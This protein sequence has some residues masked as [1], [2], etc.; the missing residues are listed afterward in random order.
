MINFLKKIFSQN[1]GYKFSLLY[2]WLFNRNSYIAH[3]DYVS[4]DYKQKCVHIMEAMNYVKVAQ[5][6]KVF[7]EFGCHSGRTFSAAIRA[8][9]EINIINETEFYAFDSFVGLPKTSSDDGIFE[10][11]TFHTGVS[12]FKK[13]L[14]TQA[15]YNLNDKYIYK[16]FYSNTLTDELQ[17]KMPKVGVVHIDVDIYSSAKEVLNFIKPL[18]VKGSVLIFDDYYCFPAGS[19]K[20][21]HRA[22]NEFLN[23][24][25]SFKITEWK[26]YSSF[27]KS[28]FITDI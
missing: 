15:D 5:L 4:S 14:K 8:S 18:L 20:G 3:K 19:N 2:L 6:P 25:P 21:E 22:L 28:F 24:N 26:A 27:G 12:D 11:G 17:K 13:A 7:F 9:K 16:G 23:E 1:L 10:E